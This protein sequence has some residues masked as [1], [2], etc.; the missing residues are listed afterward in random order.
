MS[1]HTQKQEQL[2]SNV[3]GSQRGIITALPRPLPEKHKT[4]TLETTV[5]SFFHPLLF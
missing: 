3:L 4:L 2:T 5:I 1:Y